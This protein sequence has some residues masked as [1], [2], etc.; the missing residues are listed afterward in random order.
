MAIHGKEQVEI[1]YSWNTLARSGSKSVKNK[2]IVLINK[3]LLIYYTIKEALNNYITDYIVSTDSK[4]IPKVS[5][6][7]GANVPFLR[8]KRLSGDSKP[9]ML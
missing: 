4:E 7:Y 3:K 5:L 2:N 6:K 9:Q 8:P 1:K